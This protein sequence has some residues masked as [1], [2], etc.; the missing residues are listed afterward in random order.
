MVVSDV[1]FNVSIIIIEE[2]TFQINSFM[3][4]FL[5]KDV[6]IRGEVQS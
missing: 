5:G 6:V 4:I 2:F 3:F 1:Y